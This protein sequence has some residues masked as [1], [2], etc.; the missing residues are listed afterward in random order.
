MTNLQTFGEYFA[1]WGILEEIKQGSELLTAVT[2]PDKQKAFPNA[3]IESGYFYS[4]VSGG[5]VVFRIYRI[6]DGMF[7]GV[8][9]LVPCDWT[10]NDEGVSFN[11][12]T[13][14]YI[15]EPIYR[16]DRTYDALSFHFG[17]GE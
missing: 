5:T 1:D 9:Q 10:E 6:E 11:E 15:T 17:S 13:E 7:Q 4:F 8:A 12:T 16:V 3:I 14:T 2:N